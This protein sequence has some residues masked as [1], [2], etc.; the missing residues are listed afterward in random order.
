MKWNN[1]GG[2]LARFAVSFVFPLPKNIP[3]QKRSPCGEQKKEEEKAREKELNDSIQD[4]CP[5][6]KSASWNAICSCIVSR[7]SSLF[8]AILLVDLCTNWTC[9]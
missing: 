2:G 1:N 6:A 7:A 9:L 8:R 4:C 5:S 3:Y